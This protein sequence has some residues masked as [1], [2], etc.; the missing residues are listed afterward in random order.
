VTP[1]YA[2]VSLAIT[3]ALAPVGGTQPQSA[4]NAMGSNLK[5]AANGG[6]F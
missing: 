6:L 3:K 5:K 1:A 2:D 4:V